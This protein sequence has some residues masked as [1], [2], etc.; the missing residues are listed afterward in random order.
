MSILDVPLRLFNATDPQLGT[1]ARHLRHVLAGWRLTWTLIIAISV[2]ATR[3]AALIGGVS[4]ANEGIRI[5]ARTSAVLFL[6]AF[7][8]SSAYQLWP[9]DF[10]KWVRRN[11]RYLGVSFAGSHLVHAAFIVASILLDGH[12]FRT[13]VAHTPHAIYALDSVAYVFIVAMTL[14]SFDR[15]AKRMRYTAWRSIHLTGSYVIWLTF[16]VAY[17][18]RGVT[19]PLFY[20]PFLMIVLGALVVR[21]IASAQRKRPRIASTLS[22]K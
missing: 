4:G 13:G 15:I 2:Y 6:L 11:R 9:N 18:R 16:F 19:Y 21:A 7:T 12:R 14:T 1:V 3:V 5:T 10:T 8:A 20:G 22:E 17:W